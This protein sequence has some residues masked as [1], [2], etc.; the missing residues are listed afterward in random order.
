MFCGCF[1]IMLLFSFLLH[2]DLC[3]NTK[4]YGKI[5]SKRQQKKKKINKFVNRTRKLG[6]FDLLNVKHLHLVVMETV[7]YAVPDLPTSP[8][9]TFFYL[10]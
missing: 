5:I 2:K 8:K 10:S 4:N 3:G 6:E 7:E 9:S 1:L